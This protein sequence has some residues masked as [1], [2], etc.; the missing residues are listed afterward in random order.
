MTATSSSDNGRMKARYFDKFIDP[1][2]FVIGSSLFGRK[3]NLS[4]YTLLKLIIKNHFNGI[5]KVNFF[6][7]YELK[8]ENKG[9]FTAYQADS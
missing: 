9:R 2:I 7:K 5:E 4:K 3:I 8:F 1:F 6:G